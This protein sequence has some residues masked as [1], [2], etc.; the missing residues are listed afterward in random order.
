MSKE[1]YIAAH[2]EL[3]EEYLDQ[4]PDATDDEAYERTAYGAWDRMTDRLAAAA[5][6]YRDMMKE[7]GL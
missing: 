6:H 1:L 5:D 2:E 4:H 7:R 3:V